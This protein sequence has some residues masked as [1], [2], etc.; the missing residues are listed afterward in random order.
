MA[1]EFFW[2]AQL[3]ERQR[4]QLETRVR[5]LVKAGF[6]LFKISKDYLVLN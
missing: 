4:V 5:I 1:Q 3:V 2:E 6:F